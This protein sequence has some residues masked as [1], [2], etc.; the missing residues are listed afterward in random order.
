[1][2]QR[3]AEL[4]TANAALQADIAERARA[5]EALRQ[6][7]ERYRSLVE[8]AKDV[9][10]T[11][12]PDGTVTSL[13]PAFATIT[14]WAGA[15]WLGKPFVPLLLA[16]DLPSAM[17]KFQ[18]A[19]QG[20]MPPICELR[21]LSKTGEYLVGEFTTTPQVQDGRVVSIWARIP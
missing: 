20:E 9:I 3:T 17:E 5:E 6:S 12:A 18:Q 16:D 4:A 1:M 7:E 19:L 14:G 21:V 2:Q 13:N 15:E 8:N 11:L 10:F